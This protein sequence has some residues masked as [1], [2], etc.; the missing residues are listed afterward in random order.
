MLLGLRYSFILT[1]QSLNQEGSFLYLR[2]DFESSGNL[3]SL[4]NKTKIITENNGHHYF[5][6]IPYAQY[7]RGSFDFR[8]HIDIGNDSWLVF[9]QFVGL[10]FPYGNSKDLPFE[11]SF[12]GGG[13][14]GLRGWIYRTVGP[15]GYVPSGDY[16]E[17]TGDIQLE[18]N[19][20][21]RFPIY[22]MF[23]GAVFFDAGNVW[24]YYPN[25]SM[26]NAEFRFNKFYK[27]LAFD[28]GL[29]VRMDLSFLII[30]LDFAYAMRN[31]YPDEDGNYWRFGKGNNIRMQM[32]IGYPF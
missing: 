21:Y 15:G 25:E 4:F 11:R 23:N 18:V 9:R 27:Q 1:N 6:G 3:L 31:P 13:S 5:L 17:S 30:R 2:A 12:Y 10:G 24:A 7:V 16:F 22:D 29:G 8:Q 26:P 20:E 14:N 28:A 19:A 32:G